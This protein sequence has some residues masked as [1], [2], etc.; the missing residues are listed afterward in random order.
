VFLFGQAISCL[1]N[2]SKHRISSSRAVN[3]ELGRSRTTLTKNGEEL[4]VASRG[5]LDVTHSGEPGD[6]YIDAK[7]PEV[8]LD[9][10]VSSHQLP[11]SNN[12]S[13]LSSAPN[14]HMCTAS[15]SEGQSPEV[16]IPGLIIHVVPIKNGASPLRKT[17]MTRHKDKSYKAFIANR[18][19]FMDLVV[20]PRMF[21]DHLP[22]RYNLKNSIHLESFFSSSCACGKS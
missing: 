9:D 21:L 15:L 8:D 22:W 10:S 11:H 12:G 17:L 2:T 3:Y 1:I 4:T 7:F 13:E 5:V 14:A 6:A 18:H 20:T 16:Y 19:D